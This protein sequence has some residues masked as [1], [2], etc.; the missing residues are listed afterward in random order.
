MFSVALLCSGE[1]VQVGPQQFGRVEVSA[2]SIPGER[3][4]TLDIDLLEVGTHKS[5]KSLLKGAVAAKIPYGTYLVRVSVPGFRRSEREIHLNQPEVLVR[6]QLSVSIECGGFAEI[7]GSI[8]SAPADHELWVKVVPLQGVGGL[9]L[10]SAE[11]DLFSP[12]VWTSDSTCY[13]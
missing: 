4:S 1:C 10:A 3:L 9:R 12:A 2:F 13:L 5:F 8:H 7:R 6:M 11:T